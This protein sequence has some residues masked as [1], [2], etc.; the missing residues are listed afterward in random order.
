[1]VHIH[2]TAV[3]TLHN[4]TQ[5]A[6]RIL[7]DAFVL[8]TC[9]YSNVLHAFQTLSPKELQAMATFRV[10]GQNTARTS[11]R[12]LVKTL[13]GQEIPAIT[14]ALAPLENSLRE[15]LKF[16]IAETLLSYVEL[17][18]EAKQQPSYPAKLRIQEREP[19]RQ[20]ALEGLCSLADNLT[21]ES[22]LV[23]QL[24]RT[25][26][27]GVISIPFIRIDHDRNCGLFYNPETRRFYARL[28]IVSPKSRHAKPI[29]IAGEYIDLKSGDTYVRKQDQQEDGAT[30]GLSKGSILV[31]LEMGRWHETPLRFTGTAFLSHRQSTTQESAI[32]VSAKLVKTENTYQLH[33]SF[34]FPPP[35][36]LQ[37]QTFLGIDRGIM[38]LAAGTVT[39]LDGKQI[40]EEFIISGKPLTELQHQ[41]EHARQVSQSKGKSTKGD[42][43]RARVADAH[44]HLCA[45]Q[46]VELA[47]RHQSQIIIGDLSPFLTSQKRTK[48]QRHSPLHTLLSRQQFHKLQNALDAKLVLV[49][50]PPVR[51]VGVAFTSITC[52]KCGHIDTANRTKDNWTHFLCTHCGHHTHAD[53]QAGTNLV[54]KMLWLTLRGQEKKQHVPEADRTSWETFI[55]SYCST[56]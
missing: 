43:R 7:D 5:R 45:N 11:T 30:F 42:H 47:I 55:K 50:L 2:R 29:D 18:K 36:R 1:M 33:V 25:K 34:R 39:S 6:R 37:P 12:Q 48:E 52:T 8:Y 19:A 53:S 28:F 35:K 38:N 31:P 56:L 27:A 20:E 32:P 40:L 51:T 13:F 41:I 9:A 22:D 14:A 21:K 49:G 3:F 15:S 23:A 46:I 16:H 24:Q 17:S 26:Q 10:D 4:P 44:I 54:R